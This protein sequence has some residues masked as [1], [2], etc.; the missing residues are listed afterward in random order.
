M[1][2]EQK[3]KTEESAPD[4]M[5]ELK[6]AEVTAHDSAPA[7][8]RDHKFRPRGAWY[9]LCEICSKA[10]SAHEATELQ[11][12]IEDDALVAYLEDED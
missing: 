5:G 6:K 7:I 2:S 1:T 11:Y 3:V 9:T 4:L 8:I 10:E 12:V